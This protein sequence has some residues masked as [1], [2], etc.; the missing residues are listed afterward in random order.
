[1]CE[2]AF[3]DA[4]GAFSDGAALARAASEIDDCVVWVAHRDGGLKLIND[5]IERWTGMPTYSAVGMGWLRTVGPAHR[6][7]CYGTL[8]NAL[9]ESKPWALNFSLR[10]ADD[11]EF[12]VVAGARCVVDPRRRRLLGAVGACVR[13][14]S[15]DPFHRLRT[16]LAEFP[17]R[18]TALSTRGDEPG[19]D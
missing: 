3:L 18:V 8:L 2:A 10:G 7:H 11:H 13:L 16:V 19:P 14:D 9:R 17:G 15:P 12:W 1:M 6:D 4:T 5:A